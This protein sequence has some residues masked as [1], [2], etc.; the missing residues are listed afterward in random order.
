VAAQ[1]DRLIGRP[2]PVPLPEPPRFQ[3][4]AAE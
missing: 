1:M 2:V 4:E 3:G